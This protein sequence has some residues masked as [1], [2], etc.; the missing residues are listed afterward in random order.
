M[1]AQLQADFGLHALATTRRNAK[2]ACNK[3]TAVLP[4]FQGLSILAR[5]EHRMVGAIGHP[6][7][8][9]VRAPSATKR[10]PPTAQKSMSVGSI[11]CSVPFPKDSTQQISTQEGADMGFRTCGNDICYLE[12]GV[13]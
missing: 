4:R 12:L 10:S 9:L 13:Q 8:C 7:L 3:T 11:A 6:L 2:S 1:C 5:L